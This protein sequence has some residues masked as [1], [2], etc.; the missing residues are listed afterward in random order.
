MTMHRAMSL[1]RYNL[2]HNYR[3]FTNGGLGMESISISCKY[4]HNPKKGSRSDSILLC[5]V[6]LNE[7]P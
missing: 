4:Y 6:P 3:L 1:A 2:A 7:R 5:D